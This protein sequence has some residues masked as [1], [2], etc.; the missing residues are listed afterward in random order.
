MPALP[1]PGSR[2][3]GALDRPVARPVRSHARDREEGDR[4]FRGQCAASR[5]LSSML[6]VVW[7]HPRAA[8]PARARASSPGHIARQGSLSCVRPCAAQPADPL[9][10]DRI[11]PIRWRRG[12]SARSAVNTAS[13]LP[14]LAAP[15]MP[16]SSPDRFP[17]PSPSPQRYSTRICPS[18]RRTRRPARTAR[19]TAERAHRKWDAP[20][21]RSTMSLPGTTRW[22][23]SPRQRVSAGLSRHLKDDGAHA[24]RRNCAAWLEKSRPNGPPT[25]TLAWLSTMRSCGRARANGCVF[26]EATKDGERRR[27][28]CTA[29]R[30][31]LACIRASHRPDD[32][33]EMVVINDAGPEPRWRNGCAACDTRTH[34]AHRARSEPRLR[35][36]GE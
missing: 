17:R 32:C 26:D 35:R 19:G 12:G 18:S 27:I 6:P 4:A 11:P 14:A 28:R 25:T 24:R 30:P 13:E 10:R 36:H 31:K 21:P 2:A 29:A 3:V 15:A 34:H 8:I 1:R 16:F 22:T 20:P 7:P 23:Q 33:H 5:V 9:P